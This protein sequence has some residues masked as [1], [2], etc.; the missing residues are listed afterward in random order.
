MK[1]YFSLF[2][3]L[4]LAAGCNPRT[5]PPG[6]KIEEKSMLLLGGENQYVEITGENDAAPVLLFIHGGPGWPQTPFLRYF[7]SDLTKKF[8]LVSWDQRGCGKSYMHNPN[9]GNMTLAQVVNDAHELTAYLK[10]KF[11][12]DRSIYL[13]GF[14]WG[15]IVGMELAQKYPDDYAAYIAISQVISLSKGTQVAREWLAE[16]AKKVND[17]AT[18]N[19]LAKLN[20]KDTAFCK[21]DLDCFMQQSKLI[22]KY[23]GDVFNDSA[24]AAEEK[25]MNAYEDYKTYDWM[26]GF[27]FSARHFEKDMFAA[28][29]STVEQLQLPVY[30]LAGKN[31]WQV[32]SVI[33]QVY[34]DNFSAPEKKIFWFKNSGHNVP[35]E[36]PALFNDILIHKILKQ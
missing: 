36:E 9:P 11:G 33:T 13:A 35:E 25:A 6:N 21:S 17:T 7:N 15:S 22:S 23:K 24:Y 30:F 16:Q 29:F 34:Y 3:V 10:K 27:E 14:S 4:L 2:I 5:Q 18:L 19:T 32:P 1:I 20:N 8:V 26:K 31:D 28:D 12:N